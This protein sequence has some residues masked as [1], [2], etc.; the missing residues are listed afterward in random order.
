MKIGYDAKRAFYNYSGL[1]NYSRSALLLLQ[2]YYPDNEYYLYT[3]KIKNAIPFHCGKPFIVRQP[4]S[5][6]AKKFSAFWRSLSMS[7]AINKDRLD[8][9]HGLSN[10]L[11]SDIENA[12]VKSIVTIHDLIFLRFPQFFSRID[13]Q[14]YL[15][16]FKNSCLK[17]DKIIAVSEQTKHDIV[18]YFQI[19]PEKIVV[20]YQGCASQFW[21][22]VSESKK[23]EVKKKYA[24]PDTFV[25]NVGTIEPRKNLISLIHSLN[26]AKHD[27]KIV[28]IGRPVK[29][30]MAELQQLIQR[31]K[32]E[33]RVIFLHNV[34][35]EDLPAIY[36]TASLFAYPSFFEGFGIP[37]VEAMASKVPVI[38]SKGSCFPETGG[39]AA[40]YIN[41]NNP[42]EIAILTDKIL[43]DGKLRQEMIAKG[44][45]HVQKFSDEAVVHSLMGVYKSV[46]A[47]K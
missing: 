40:I 7:S 16:K 36:Q 10:E 37:I 4:D 24:L 47:E 25:L 41:P 19:A 5:F 32:L 23:V 34:P 8:I 14:I 2:Q 46:M 44:L 30:Y 22:T 13:N 31:K 29:K 18:N 43:E 35:N 6:L 21:D 20:S 3:P 27:A 26:Y 11:P 17:A 9:F 33:D 15:R 12:N 38:T 39:D 1:G 42:E 45:T 28:A